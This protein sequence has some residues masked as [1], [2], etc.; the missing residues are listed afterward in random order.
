[1][2]TT[3]MPSLSGN[4]RAVLYRLQSVRGHALYVIPSFVA[5]EDRTALRELEIA[6]LVQLRSTQVG[7]ISRTQAKL[8]DAGRT[9]SVPNPWRAS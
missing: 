1:M 3:T 6:G 7:V 8:T 2:T 5:P 4:A 9:T